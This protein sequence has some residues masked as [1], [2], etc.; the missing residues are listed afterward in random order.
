MIP[1]YKLALRLVG[2][3]AL[4]FS[5]ATVVALAGCGSSTPATTTTATNTP[6]ASAPTAT[7]APPANATTINIT[8]AAGNYV[9]QPASVTIKAGSTVVWSNVSG[10]PHTSTSDSGDAI[11]W[12]SSTINTGGGSFSF[13]FTKPG[14]Y[15]YHCSFHPFMHGT[16]VVTG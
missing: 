12:D 1:A 15:P 8:G 5:L 2:R 3:G 4:V 13:T 7:S 9:F 6:S 16:I 10:V 11:S 14:T